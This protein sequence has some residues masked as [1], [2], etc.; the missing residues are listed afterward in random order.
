MRKDTRETRQGQES[1]P[2]RFAETTPPQS[3]PSGDYSYV[4]EIVMHMQSSMGQL[5]EAVNSL[6]SESKDHGKELHEIS[7]DVHAAK[8]TMKIL[9]ALILAVGG[10]IAWL[11]N[12]YISTH[13]VK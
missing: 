11:I 5:L 6:K 12:T 8:T 13:P 3:L 4:L 10:V 9:G 7:K 1:T 2:S